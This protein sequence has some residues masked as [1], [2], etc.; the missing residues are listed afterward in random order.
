[1]LPLEGRDWAFG[2]CPFL[3]YLEM[4]SS[5]RDFPTLPSEGWEYFLALR[6][7]PLVVAVVV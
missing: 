3:I 2:F 4:L 7:F 1:L 6:V 5:P